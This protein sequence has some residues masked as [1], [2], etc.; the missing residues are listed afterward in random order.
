MVPR[1]AFHS[2][3]ALERSFEVYQVPQEDELEASLAH[4]DPYVLAV[5]QWDAWHPLNTLA[6]PGEPGDER[7]RG[8][9]CGRHGDA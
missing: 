5:M 1:A 3:C 6:L 2:L 9:I 8:A 7:R 4:L